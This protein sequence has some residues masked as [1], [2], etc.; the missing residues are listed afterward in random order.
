MKV[1]KTLNHINQRSQKNTKMTYNWE[2]S[3]KVFSAEQKQDYT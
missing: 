3:I 2:N 1:E